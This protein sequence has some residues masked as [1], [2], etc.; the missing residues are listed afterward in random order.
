M[1]RLLYSETWNGLVLVAK[2]GAQVRTS[3]AIIGYG[4]HHDVDPGQY[5]VCT[6]YFY[7]DSGISYFQT[8][9]GWFVIANDNVT[10]E[11]YSNGKKKIQFISDQSAQK[12]VDTIITNN[13]IILC[14]NLL[15]ARFA[16]KL[17]ERQRNDIRGLQ[18]RL[19]QRNNALQA[20]GLVRVD[21]TGKPG[22]YA[23]LSP[24][25]DRLMSGEAIGFATWVTIIIYAT[26][27]AGLGTAAYYG[28]KAIADESE[29]DVK[30][31]KEL[32]NILTSKLTD[33]EYQQ[34]LSETRGI[35]TK[36]KIKST[37][38]SYWDVVKWAAIGFAGYTAYKF[39]NSRL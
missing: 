25:L 8:T 14:N 5:V 18:E 30:Y 33:E 6:G 16:N 28:Y 4:V 15:C 38:G 7:E 11:W 9:S 24:Y 37:L 29:R 2:Q 13:Q 21:S 10:N 3:P 20:E 31:S 1:T 34:L 23:E 17:N 39:I 32:T 12:L 22:G 19:Q 36:A 27:I 26:V 35:V